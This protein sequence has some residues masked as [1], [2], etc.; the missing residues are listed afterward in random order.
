MY[1]K[2]LTNGYSKLDVHNKYM[3]QGEIYMPL[4]TSTEMFKK[5]YEVVM[6]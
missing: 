2:I 6:Q 3:T 4:I 5:A 1:D